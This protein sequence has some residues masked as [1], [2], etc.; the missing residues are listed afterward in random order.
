RAALL[1]RLRGG[2][3]G[4]AARDRPGKGALRGRPR[5][6][7]AARRRAGEPGGILRAPGA[8]RS[9]PGP[10]ARPRRPPDARPQGQLLGPALRR[11]RLRGAARGLADR[12][13]RGGAAALSIMSKL[14][15]SLPV[16]DSA[17]TLVIAAVSVVF[18]WSM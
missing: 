17:S 16:P 14:V 13:R 1:R 11:P 8:R 5:K 12:L 2:R 7:P 15:T 3:R 9:H 4:R 6:R 18:P 10:S